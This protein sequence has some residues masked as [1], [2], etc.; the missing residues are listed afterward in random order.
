[1]LLTP[2]KGYRRFCPR[3]EGI[4]VERVRRGWWEVQV[5][6]PPTRKVLRHRTRTIKEAKV[7]GPTALA[8]RF[9]GT[10]DT[11]PSRPAPGP[12]T[13]QRRRPW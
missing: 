2:G 7:W 1:M 5:R 13:A 10:L 3:D 8:T 11:R 6:R 9:P 12:R 4:R